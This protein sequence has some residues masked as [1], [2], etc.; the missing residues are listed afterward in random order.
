MKKLKNADKIHSDVICMRGKEIF[1]DLF[2]YLC[3]PAGGT[4]IEVLT[5]ALRQWAPWMTPESP[6]DRS[7]PLNRGRSLTNIVRRALDREETECMSGWKNN[8]AEWK[9]WRKRVKERSMKACFWWDSKSQHLFGLGSEKSSVSPCSARGNA[10][11]GCMGFYEKQL[12]VEKGWW[13]EPEKE[14]QRGK[15]RW[16]REKTN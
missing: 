15:E 1:H 5:G 7:S 2:H 6:K 11:P 14:R 13:R 4:H 10:I 9:S 16:E 8:K 3:T 12:Y